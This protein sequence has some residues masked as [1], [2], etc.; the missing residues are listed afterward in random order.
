MDQLVALQTITRKALA[1]TK[2]RDEIKRIGRTLV[3]SSFYYMSHEEP[4]LHTKGGLICKGKI[5]YFRP[6]EFKS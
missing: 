1:K 2:A 5:I 3:A 6:V 4:Q